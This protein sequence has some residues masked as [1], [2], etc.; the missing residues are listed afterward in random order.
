MVVFL[1][2]QVLVTSLPFT[3][4]DADITKTAYYDYDSNTRTPSYSHHKLSTFTYA[5]GI[6][7]V[8]IDGT[9]TGLTDLDMFYFKVAQAYGDVIR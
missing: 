9:D 3:I 6:N 7:N 8:L 2:L 5:D 4:F 1:G